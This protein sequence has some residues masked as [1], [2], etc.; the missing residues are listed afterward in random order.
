[1]GEYKR[2]RVWYK[3]IETTLD[4]YTLPIDEYL[5][6]FTQQGQFVKGVHYQLFP[7]HPSDKL[8]CFVK[9]LTHKICRLLLIFL[10]GNHPNKQNNF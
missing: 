9:A 3:W 7:T 4:V 1:M 8:S 10:R 2:Y 6:D 5:T